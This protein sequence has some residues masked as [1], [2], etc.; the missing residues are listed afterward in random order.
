MSVAIKAQELAVGYKSGSARQVVLDGLNVCARTGELICLL[1]TN[2]TGKSTLLRTLARIQPALSGSVEINGVN[3][4]QLSQMELAR[5]IGVVLTERVMVGALTARRVVELGR[6]P[7]WDWSGRMTQSD[8]DVV[9]WAI[10]AVGAA[11]LA[12]RDSTSLSDG[13]RQRFMIARAL[14]QEPSIL[15]LDEPTAFLDVPARVEVMGLLRR[16]ARDEQLAVVV[17]TH[18]LELAL[19]MADTL[20]LVGPGNKLTAGTPED[21]IL[22]GSVAEAFQA[23]SIRFHPEERAFRL[24]TDTRGYAI[25]RGDGLNAVLA[26]AV[27]EREGYQIVTHGAEALTITVDRGSTCWELTEGRDHHSGTSFATLAELARAL[28]TE[29]RTLDESNPPRAANLRN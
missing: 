21:I 18:D 4:Q 22:A 11:H 25:V 16:L 28:S 19:R 1:G 17:S 5:R 8:H 6:Y 2:G 23:E 20:W 9:D 13:E 29:K 15:L 24:V 12:S 27:M 7:Y 14:A 26:A 3:L 10:E